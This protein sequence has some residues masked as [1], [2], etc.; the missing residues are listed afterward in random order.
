MAGSRPTASA[1]GAKPAP[2]PPN[3][4]SHLALGDDRRWGFTLTDVA[5]EVLMRTYMLAIAVA[6]FAIPTAVFSESGHRRYHNRY[7]GLYNRYDESER[8]ENC[9]QLVRT[10]KN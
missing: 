9:E 1:T 8:A 2:P 6:L 3:W 10:K 7:E 4:Y 5:L